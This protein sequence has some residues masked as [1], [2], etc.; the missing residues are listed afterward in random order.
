[1]LV[2]FR[3]ESEQMGI[4]TKIEWCDDTVNPTMGCDGCELWSKGRRIC[5][6]GQLHQLRKGHKGYAPSFDVVTHFPGRIEA[7]AR[8]PSLL[9]QTRPSKPWLDGL[10]RLIFVSDMGDSLSKGV[11]FRFLEEEIIDQVSSGDGQRH[12]WLWLTKRPHRMARFSNWLKNR[13]RTWPTNLWAR[14]SL[15]TQK[16]VGRI[17]HLLKVGDGDTIRF[18][19][20]EPQWA[21]I[22]LRRWLPQLDWVIQGGQSGSDQRAFELRWAYDLLKHCRQAGVPYFLK[23]LGRFATHNGQPL[24]L[25]DKMGGSWLEWPQPLRVREMP[26]LARR[27]MLGPSPARL[28]LNVSTNAS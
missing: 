19:S 2:R 23:Q 24:K 14:T 22:D 4:G 17:N 3:K 8:K 1:M 12:E 25:K 11:P 9:G 16:T 27:M 7:I 18:L 21:W 13:G 20:V 26:S 15:T 6:A 10:A 28:S 5:Y